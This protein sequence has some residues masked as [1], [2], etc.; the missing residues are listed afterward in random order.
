[1]NLL[2]K[3]YLEKKKKEES[4]DVDTLKNQLISAI[5]KNQEEMKDLSEKKNNALLNLIKIRNKKDLD[6][7]KKYF[8]KYKN[9]VFGIDK[10]DDDKKE[11]IKKVIVKT[12]DIKDSKPISDY[13]ID[14]YDDNES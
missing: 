2:K 5:K 13:D 1:L 11:I 6:I 9:N 3:L 12:I 4:E 7:I 14:K 10:D 8:D